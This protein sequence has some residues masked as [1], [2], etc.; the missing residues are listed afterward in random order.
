MILSL[1]ADPEIKLVAV[2]CRLS[3]KWIYV[4][5]ACRCLRGKSWGH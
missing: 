5:D 4:N 3:V 2:L 1:L